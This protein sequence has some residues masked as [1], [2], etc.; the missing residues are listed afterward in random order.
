[1]QFRAGRS[2]R[3]TLPQLLSLG[4]GTRS[5]PVRRNLEPGQLQ[6]RKKNCVGR[7]T[8]AANEWDKGREMTMYSHRV[9]LEVFRPEFQV[10]C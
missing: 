9:L 10:V 6:H 5:V 2:P 4:T 3:Q 7:N 1:M 8:W